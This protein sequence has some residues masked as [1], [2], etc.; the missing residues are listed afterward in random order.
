MN[1]KINVYANFISKQL[2]KEGVINEAAETVS[3]GDNHHIM[4]TQ[5][6]DN[7]M[8]YH[9]HMNGKKFNA[10]VKQVGDDD[11]MAVETKRVHERL[12]AG[13]KKN[14]IEGADHTTVMKHIMKHA[15]AEIHN[16]YHP[17]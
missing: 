7:D 15:K 1:D 16:T 8:K 12:S 14:G 9:G 11:D 17:D 2:I 13:L 5:G 10:T 6:N 3:K 4:F